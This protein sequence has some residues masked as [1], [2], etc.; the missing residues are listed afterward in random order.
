MNRPGDLEGSRQRKS[1][2]IGGIDAADSGL[3]K[4]EPMNRNRGA[5]RVGIGQDKAGQHEEESNRRVTRPQS[6]SQ[7]KNGSVY[8]WKYEMIKHYVNG[9]DKSQA[10]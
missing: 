1:E 2:K 8:I 6:V 5:R 7:W 10:R 4:A 3:P 9:R